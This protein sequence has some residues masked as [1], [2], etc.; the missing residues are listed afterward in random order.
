MLRELVNWPGDLLLEQ[1]LRLYDRAVSAEPDVIIEVGRGY[2]N[3]TVVLTEAAHALPARVISVSNDMVYGWATRTRPCLEPVLGED[4][5]NPLT[6]V[7]GDVRDFTPPPCERPFLFWDAHGPEVADAI[8]G[9]LLPALPR[10]ATSVVVHDVSTREEAAAHPSEWGYP[11]GW[12]GLVSS[13]EELPL[14]GRWLDDRGIT[15]DQD[16]GMLAFTV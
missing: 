4:W 14:I 12:R 10:R 1:W 9:R 11:H 6:V 13:F 5:F 8:L 15:P 16:T 7:Q 2:G 3:S